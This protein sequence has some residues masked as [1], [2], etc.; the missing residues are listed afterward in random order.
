MI[1]NQRQSGNDNRIT[2]VSQPTQINLVINGYKYPAELNDTTTAQAILAK[3]PMTVT[4]SQ[5]MHDCCGTTDHFP[6]DQ[7][8][9]QS[10]WFNG[11][12]AFDISGDWFVIFLRGANNDPQYREVKIGQLETTDEIQQIAAL[13]D[14]I[15]VKIERAKEGL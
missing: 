11:D 10:G 1:E 12:L 4:V 6:Y 3:L 15:E 9:V 5:G 8:N 2:T 14:T 13:P 7:S